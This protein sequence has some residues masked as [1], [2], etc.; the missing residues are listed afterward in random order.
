M[1]LESLLS[2]YRRQ[3]M[4]SITCV[5]RLALLEQIF[6]V[7]RENWSFIMACRPQQAI[8]VQTFFFFKKSVLNAIFLEAKQSLLPKFICQQAFSLSSSCREGAQ[9]PRAP[10]V[11]GS[12]RLNSTS[13]YSKEAFWPHDPLRTSEMVL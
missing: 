9:C 2:F 8:A 7:I 11:T 12:W 6:R 3:F 10:L 5:F 1:K 13:V 4:W